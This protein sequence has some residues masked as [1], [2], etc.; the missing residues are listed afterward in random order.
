MVFQNTIHMTGLPSRELSQEKNGNHSMPT[1]YYS[2]LI[3]HAN[4]IKGDVMTALHMLNKNA[5]NAATVNHYVHNSIAMYTVSKLYDK[6][7]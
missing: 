6:F 3:F 7:I 2:K 1:R 4:L 5:S